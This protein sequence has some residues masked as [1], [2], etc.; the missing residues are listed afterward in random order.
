MGERQNPSLRA[1]TIRPPILS[2]TKNGAH[3][4]DYREP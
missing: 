1:S 3:S 4:Q 2:L